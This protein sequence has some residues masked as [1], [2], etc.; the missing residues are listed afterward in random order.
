MS[1]PSAPLRLLHRRLAAAMG[2]A[3]LAAFVSGAGI[4]TPTPIIAAGALGLALF[5]APG[6][7]L[8]RVLDP[9]WRVLAL[10]LAARALFLVVTS[11]E[12]VVLPMVDLLLVLLLS[13]TLK[14]S[15]AAG[16]T[17]VYS[18]SF[19]LL[20]ASSAYRPGVVFALSFV[21]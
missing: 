5:W 15:G 14:E 21:S 8:P 7:R 20:V 11:P 19:A 9:L 17:R 18:L 3:A 16:D 12:D 6:P 13:E 10:L 4:E 2:L 1:G